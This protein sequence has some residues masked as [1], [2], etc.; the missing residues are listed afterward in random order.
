[1]HSD[2][3]ISSRR[4]GPNLVHY[5][6]V[7]PSRNGEEAQK[8][9]DETRGY[10]GDRHMAWHVCRVSSENT[11]VAPLFFLLYF[12]P[13]FFRRRLLR[14]RR[15]MESHGRDRRRFSYSIR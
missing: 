8:I 1:M 5:P 15:R 6:V 7:S 14:E 3:L 4:A 9:L 10:N 2:R 11:N 13:P 12:L